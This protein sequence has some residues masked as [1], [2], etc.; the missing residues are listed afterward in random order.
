MASNYLSRPALDPPAP[1]AAEKSFAKTPTVVSTRLFVGN[2]SPAVDEYTLIQ[3]FSKCGRIAKMDFLFHKTGPLKGKPRGYAFVEYSTKEEAAKAVAKLHDRSLRGRK[4][5]VSYAAAVNPDY[6]N[7]LGSGK[8]Y[9]RGEPPKT[10]TLSLIKG[11]RK[12]Q[13]A[14]AQIAALEAKLNSMQ[15]SPLALTAGSATPE[16]EAGPSD[17]GKRRANEEASDGQ[18]IISE[19]QPQRAKKA[20][21]EG[22]SRPSIPV[23]PLTANLPSKPSQITL[24]TARYQELIKKF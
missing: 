17:K 3:V 13:S 6:N 1:S 20:K 21:T 7:P 18:G 11:H 10:T 24:D 14:E 8:P 22:S 12:P 4:L 9:R 5:A 19:D 16:P 15:Q 23:P 2:L